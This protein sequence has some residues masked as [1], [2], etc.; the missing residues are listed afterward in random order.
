MN[1][2]IKKQV[3]WEGPCGSIS[4]TNNRDLL[5]LFDNDILLKYFSDKQSSDDLKKVKVITEKSLKYLRKIFKS[6]DLTSAYHNFDHNYTTTV[7]SFRA[8]I[9]ALKIN[10]SITVND[11]KLLLLASLFHDTGYLLNSSF[12]SKSNVVTH[13]V[14][15]LIFMESFVKKLDWDNRDVND[16]LILG[17]FTDYSKWKKD[18]LKIIN[19]DC[20]INTVLAKIIVG[21]DFMQV[22]DRNYFDNLDILNEFLKITQGIEEKKGQKKFYNLSSDVT[23]WIWEYLD[24]FYEGKDKD[25]YRKGWKHFKSGMTKRFGIDI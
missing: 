23:Q 1:K 15:S 12:K 21:A 22:V 10:E 4:P 13:I 24:A 25:P 18:R 8:F 14:R 6:Y 20:K 7:T 16:L 11:L 2:K 5:N 3:K 17:Q 19:H 9:G